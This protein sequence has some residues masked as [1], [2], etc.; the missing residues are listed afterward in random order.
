VRQQGE[1]GGGDVVA[2]VSSF[3]DKLLGAWKSEVDCGNMM[4]GRIVWCIVLFIGPRR[5]EASVGR[6]PAR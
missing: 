4:R 5:G 3:T 2:A 1:A 6:R